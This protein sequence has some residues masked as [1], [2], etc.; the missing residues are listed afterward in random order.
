[1]QTSTECARFNMI[2]QQIRPWG[3]LDAA[4]VEALAALPR[5]S[6]VPDAYRGLAYADIEIPLGETSQMLAPKIVGRLLQALELKPGERV[7]EIGTGSG[8]VTACL[9]R[10][11]VQVVSVEIDVDLAAAARGRLTALKLDRVEVREG[12]GLAGAVAGG[13]FDA[14]VVTGSL[15]TDAAV[16]R[17]LNQLAIGGRLVCI[18]GQTPVMECIRITRIAGQEVRRESLFETSVPALL[19]VED[20]VRFEF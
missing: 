18:I 6:F 14:I 5:E 3:V 7:L 17:L 16:P 15:P 1:M 11:G 19:K 13:P 4:V 9:R 8:Y 2:Q 10:L 20:P 12:D